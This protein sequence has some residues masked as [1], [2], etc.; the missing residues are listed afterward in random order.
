MGLFKKALKSAL[1]ASTSAPPKTRSTASGGSRGS[2]IVFVEPDATVLFDPE[3]LADSIKDFGL[4]PRA[5]NRDGKVDID[6]VG[7]S[8]RQGNIRQVQQ[9]YVDSWFQIYLVQEPENRYD[10][11]AVAV[12]VGNA[13][14]GYVP[15]D[16]ARVWSK[17]VKEAQGRGQLL[18][19]EA[20]C[21]T[22]T[23]VGSSAM[24]GVFGYMWF[25]NMIAPDLST[26]EPKK[27][28]PAALEKAVA[29]IQEMSD[30]LDYPD[31]AGE[32]R[33]LGRKAGKAVLP[34]Y[35]HALWMAQSADDEPFHDKW[36]DIAGECESVFDQCEADAFNTGEDV[37]A[38][39][40]SVL[41][42]LL[43]ALQT[44]HGGDAPP[45]A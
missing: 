5:V 14:V 24:W 26:V 20:H 22:N 19:G 16:E 37:D 34:L 23:S 38:I 9:H 6:I 18:L 12:F 3:G 15:K 41:S 31:T 30:D 39:F 8:F 1:K 43:E 7:E 4:K 32:S 36:N 29:K 42:D 44:V 28:T 11:N 10:K 33:A 2:S 45:E 17:L 13:R 40:D 35:M 25:G 27:L 21:V